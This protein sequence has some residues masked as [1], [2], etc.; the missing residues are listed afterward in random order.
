MLPL[1]NRAY[2]RRQKK[3]LP[4]VPV[5]KLRVSKY[6]LVWEETKENPQNPT[7]VTRNDERKSVSFVLKSGQP[8]PHCSNTYHTRGMSG[9]R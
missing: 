9:Q 4:S 1:Y 6:I 8:T 3:A 5:L 7:F 2:T